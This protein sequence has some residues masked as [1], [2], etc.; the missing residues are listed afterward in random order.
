MKMLPKHG[1]KSPSKLLG[2][3]IPMGKWRDG[4]GSI[5]LVVASRGK[6]IYYKEYIDKI[7]LNSA[8]SLDGGFYVCKGKMSKYDFDSR[9]NSNF[10]PLVSLK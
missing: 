2:L 6:K 3:E 9:V 4:C 7:G 8:P 1:E 10:P 5:F